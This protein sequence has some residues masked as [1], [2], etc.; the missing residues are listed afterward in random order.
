MAEFNYPEWLRASE[1]PAA[2]LP[3]EYAE[4]D[5]VRAG[6]AYL[7]WLYRWF[8]N[9][10]RAVAAYNA[11]PGNLS[12]WLVGNDVK[13]VPKEETKE[14]VRHIFRGNPKAFDQQ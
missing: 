6:A 10:P 8:K 4:A 11:G 7:A 12:E 9:W 14:T 3:P 1:P 5:A 13:Y 2:D